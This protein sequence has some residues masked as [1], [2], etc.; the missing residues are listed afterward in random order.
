MTALKKYARLEASALWRAHPDDQR[1][2]VVI[3]L[4]D[5]T[6]V[7]A[8]LQDRAIT[9][10][11]L[12]AVKRANPGTRPAVFYPDGDRGETLELDA[13]EA[14]MIDALEKLRRAVDRTRPRRGRLRWLG[15]VVSVGVVA[16]L[17]VFW[18]PGALMNHAV[19]VVPPVKRVDIGTA[20]LDRIEMLTGPTCEDPSG[21]RALQKLRARLGSGPIVVVPGTVGTSLHLPGGLIVIDRALVEDHETPDV[22]AGFILAEQTLA[23]TVDP[24]H[25]LLTV[26]GGLASFQLLT[27][28]DLKD[29]TLDAY[30]EHLL[31]VLRAAPDHDAM[32]AAFAERSVSSRAYAYARDISGETVLDL[33]EADPMASRPPVPLMTDADWLRLQNICGG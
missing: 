13:N 32:L 10:W 33:I 28:G 6:L 20:L 8:D 15:V 25:H 31:T 30:S 23:A 3:S 27:T 9:H 17:G 22:V 11:S 19:S 2:E 1:R 16:A 29:E 5:A 24:L 4:G 14:Q 18:L 12:A 26:S 7:I 21:V